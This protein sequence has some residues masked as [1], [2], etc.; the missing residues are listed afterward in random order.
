[1]P[2]TAAPV[3]LGPRVRA[4]VPALVA[5]VLG[6][7]GVWAAWRVGVQSPAGRQIEA[8]VA[9]A[10]VP[11]RWSQAAGTLLGLMTNLLIV[12]GLGAAVLVA[13]VRRRWVAAG[14]AVAVVVGANV[15]GRV[16][17]H[18]LLGSAVLADGTVYGNSGPSGHTIAA[19]SLALAL[20][21]VVPARVRPTVAVLA[22]AWSTA[23]GVATV[24]SGDHRPSDAVGGL[25]VVLAA[26]AFGC[27]ASVLVE[28]PPAGGRPSRWWDSP[29]LLLVVTGLVTG[30]MA[31]VDL[32]PLAGSGASS[33]VAAQHRA[34][35][36]AVLAIA[37]T[38]ALATG[39]AA[40][41]RGVVERAA[42]PP[43]DGSRAGSARHRH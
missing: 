24:L 2:D 6:A 29:L 3:A 28:R 11:A 10:A 33:D 14:L 31:A 27:V 38:A 32:V 4:A 35:L 36:G 34:L 22:A 42:T 5:G 19:A 18:D 23:V 8:L 9:A 12:V 13:L 16:L 17:K 40:W 26:G 39:L 20:V 37:S 7:V 15:V 41:V 25:C 1:M 30:A 43:G 21:L